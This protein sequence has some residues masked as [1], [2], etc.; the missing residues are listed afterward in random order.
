MYIKSLS[1]QNLRGHKNLSMTFC[2]GINAIVGVNG[3]GKSTI[4]DAISFSLSHFVAKL[5]R[6]TAVGKSIPDS[7]I[8]I[9]KNEACIETTYEVG[10]EQVISQ[11][12]TAT[13]VGRTKNKEGML[14]EVANWAAAYHDMRTQEQQVSYPILAHYKVTR[15]ILDIPQRQARLKDI[16]EPL[17]GYDSAFEGGGNFRGFFAWF[18][19]MED[20]EKENRDELGNPEYREPE[21]EAVRVAIGKILPGITNLRIRRR[22]QAMMA[23]KRGVEMTINQLS[24]GEKCYL[25][26]IG[27]IACRL[28]RLNTLTNKS[29]EEILCSEGIVLIDE[30][31]LH[32]HPKWQRESIRHL[33]AIFPGIQ[34]IISTHSLMLLRELEMMRLEQQPAENIRYFS[35]SEGDDNT[36]RVKDS[37]S[38][39]KLENFAAAA[40]QLEQDT[41]MLSYYGYDL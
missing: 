41:Q 9:G 31:D 5:K 24:D 6:K 10:N 3:V 16:G 28:A 12:V 36:I 14:K 25:A 40:L 13:R 19:E 34:F 15:A 37:E 32:L 39:D 7:N 21:L 8:T 20:L 11:T 1:I 4:L 23:T 22:H 18:R 35:L 26:L 2:P 30:L 29:T 33:Q 27:D 17:S 38:L